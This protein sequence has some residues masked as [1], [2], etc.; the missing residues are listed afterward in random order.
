MVNSM[1]IDAP[2][3]VETRVAPESFS[4]GELTPYYENKFPGF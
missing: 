2:V 4:S 3:G 1:E